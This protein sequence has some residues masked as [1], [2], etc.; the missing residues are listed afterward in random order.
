MV[1]LPSARP[2]HPNSDFIMAPLADGSGNGIRDTK[3][4]QQFSGHWQRGRWW[5][6]AP[7]FDGLLVFQHFRSSVVLPRCLCGASA[8]SSSQRLRASPSS[9]CSS[10]SLSTP[11][12][13]GS[14]PCPVSPTPSPALRSRS[15][16]RLFFG[17]AHLAP[18]PQGCLSPQLYLCSLGS[19]SV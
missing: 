6:Q 15:R 8:A 11:H 19:Y 4:V 3:E 7:A 16:P 17:E 9:C 18:R 13:S 12:T 5:A 1:D 14:Q 10:S 2:G